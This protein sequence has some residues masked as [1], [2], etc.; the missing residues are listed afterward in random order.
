MMAYRQTE[1]PH[2]NDLSN[3]NKEA[4]SQNNKYLNLCTILFRH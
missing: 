4:S 1:N 2:K 3:E